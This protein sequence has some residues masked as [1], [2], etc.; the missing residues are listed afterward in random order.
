MEDHKKYLKVTAQGRSET[1]D[2]HNLC[3]DPK[4]DPDL[5]NKE[6]NQSGNWSINDGCGFC[7][8]N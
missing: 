2:I 8:E 6:K 4:D 7:E 3:D 5:K 1:P